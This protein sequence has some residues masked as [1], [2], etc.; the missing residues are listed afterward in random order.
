MGNRLGAKEPM[1]R[2][3]SWRKNSTI[4]VMDVSFVFV[5][6]ISAASKHCTSFAAPWRFEASSWKWVFP[7]PSQICAISCQ[8]NPKRR[9]VWW[10]FEACKKGVWYRLDAQHATQVGIFAYCGCLLCHAR[11]LA[12]GL[13]TSAWELF[14]SSAVKMRGA[15][16]DMIAVMVIFFWYSLEVEI[17]DVD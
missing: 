7:W 6:Q 1:F 13:L 3:N 14:V 11:V 2:V 8:W 16:G 4:Y 15:K 12:F 10:C 9:F 17:L 5:G